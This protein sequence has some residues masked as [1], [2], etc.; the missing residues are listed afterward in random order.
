MSYFGGNTLYRY[1]VDWLLTRAIGP[2]IDGPLN[3]DSSKTPI[4][5]NNLI[6]KSDIIERFSS[7]LPLTI[8]HGLIGRVLLN[9]PPLTGIFFNWVSFLG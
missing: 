7:E 1:V 3:V 5:L 8:E 6:I 9:I 2:F 4:E